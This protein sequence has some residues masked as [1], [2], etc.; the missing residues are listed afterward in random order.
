MICAD[1]LNKIKMHAIDDET[2]NMAYQIISFD[3]PDQMLNYDQIKSLI[4]SLVSIL[5]SQKQNSRP[6]SASLDT[7]D[8]TQV[9]SSQLISEIPDVESLFGQ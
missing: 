9:S 6:Q 1:Y 8:R 7:K 2:F 4:K 5:E 3:Q